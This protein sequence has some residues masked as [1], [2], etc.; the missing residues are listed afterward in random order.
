MGCTIVFYVLTVID[1]RS[2]KYTLRV[3]VVVINFISFSFNLKII[4]PIL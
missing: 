1:H 2:R 3:S 4:V